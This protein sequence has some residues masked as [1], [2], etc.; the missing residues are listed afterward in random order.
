M[1][2][3]STANVWAAILSTIV[4]LILFN[5]ESIAATIGVPV[6]AERGNSSI[7]F[8][9][10]IGLGIAAVAGFIAPGQALTAA[11]FLILGATGVRHMIYLAQNG[12]PNLWPIEVL[13]IVL[14]S[15]PY[16]VAAL[17]AARLRRNR[18]KSRNAT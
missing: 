11:A 2:R 9:Y 14:L 5:W 8:E 4:G 15:I 10:W 6:H 18:E 16:L 13:F 3:A 17:F 1:T 12:V 7:T